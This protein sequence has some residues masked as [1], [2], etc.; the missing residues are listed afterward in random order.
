MSLVPAL[1]PGETFD[2]IRLTTR[3]AMEAGCRA[4]WYSEVN[5]F[6]A[7]AL[8][9]GLAAAG[10]TGDMTVVVGPL[11][12]QLRDPAQIAKSLSTLDVLTPGGIELVL[13]ASSP[14][15]VEGWHGREHSSPR[16]SLEEY[17][18]VLRDALTGE[19]TNTG[20][21]YWRS[22]GF[23]SAVPTPI[24]L[25]I[26]I[27]A[28]GPKM[29]E[30]AG[31]IADRVVLNLVPPESV[32]AL[33]DRIRV[34]AISAGRSIPRVVVWITAGSERDSLERIAGILGGYSRAPGYRLRLTEAGLIKDIERNSEGAARALAAFGVSDLEERC[35]RFRATG[36]DEIAVVTSSRDRLSRDLAAFVAANQASTAA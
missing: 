30:L 3:L 7:I 12:F 29:L 16:D 34:G 11:P 28:L 19:R 2:D 18:R 36:V 22:R 20:G 31:A 8:G 26:G 23:R 10:D 6:D 32:E 4:V 21:N 13:G 9:C 33:I 15:I 14:A 27:A 1:W 25:K 17:V 5:G 24:G 35:R